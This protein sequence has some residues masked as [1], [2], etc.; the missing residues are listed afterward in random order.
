MFDTRTRQGGNIL[1]ISGEV[2]V[3]LSRMKKYWKL[4]IDEK[5][6]KNLFQMFTIFY[7]IRYIV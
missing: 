1:V 6:Y 5:L 2:I 7:K 3:V 4:N